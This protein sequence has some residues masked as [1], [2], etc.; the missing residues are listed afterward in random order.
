MPPPST[1]SSIANTGNL[2]VLG[3]ILVAMVLNL[4]IAAVALLKR[5]PSRHACHWR[6]LDQVC[7]L[8]VS[9]DR[10]QRAFIMRHLIGVANCLGGLAALN[11]GVI[12]GV[13]DPVGCAWLTWTALATIVGI[14]IL[15]RT[16]LNRHF[17]DPS[18]VAAHIIFA[19][20]FLAWGYYLGGPCR[21]VGMMLLFVVLFA[22]FFASKTKV[23]LTTS[24]AAVLCF[25]TVMARVAWEER[26]LPNGPQVQGVNFCVLLVVLTSLYLLVQHLI[27]IRATSSQRKKELV[28]AMARIQELATRDELTQLFNRRHMQQLLDTEQARCGRSG[29]P[30][31][32]AVVDID[33]FKRINDAHG[34]G[35]G[36]QA[37]KS[38]A[39]ILTAGMRELD[40]VA[41]WGGEEFLLLFPDTDSDTASV[42]LRRVLNDLG[43]A[44]VCVGKPQLRI[45]FSA[46]VAQLAAGEDTDRTIERADAALYEAKR[47]GRSR[48][49]CASPTALGDR[50]A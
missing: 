15:L 32:I 11:Y 10:R 7:K 17:A 8:L 36:D 14:T 26:E 34:H 19:E 45:T 29:R 40:V 28:A 4:G 21:T 13:I 47:A 41:R 27:H 50:V 42:V 12:R 44:V 16:G 18:L 48:V 30:F 43:K 23:V 1:L 39:A 37:L 49:T 31:S 9:G 22:N 2:L 5:G 6:H 25:G 20:V 38:V 33:H 46:G 35:V 24:I 3:L